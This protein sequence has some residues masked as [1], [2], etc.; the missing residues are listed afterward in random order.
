MH[1]TCSDISTAHYYSCRGRRFP[2]YIFEGREC[3]GSNCL[4]SSLLGRL[5]PHQA[6][7]SPLPYCLGKPIFRSAFP[8][9][10]HDFK[11]ISG[12]CAACLSKEIC[13]HL[14]RVGQGSEVTERNGRCVSALRARTHPGPVFPIIP[15]TAR[16]NALQ[17]P[18]AEIRKVEPGAAPLLLGERP[19]SAPSTF[20]PPRP[21]SLEPVAARSEP[22]RGGAGKEGWLP[23]GRRALSAGA[24]LSRCR[25][26]SPPV[27]RPLAGSRSLSLARSPFPV[28]VVCKVGC[29]VC[30]YTTS[31]AGKWTR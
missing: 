1:C 4:L 22:R 13:L 12:L 20:P 25:A 19:R 24:L 18:A 16:N 2:I 31:G 9:R 28:S 26:R 11:T 14:P 29:S 30:I 10:A 21:G 15:R 5:L 7:F 23:A 27:S 8:E 3:W 17:H 6:Q